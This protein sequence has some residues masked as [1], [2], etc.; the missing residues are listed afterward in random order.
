MGR[1]SRRAQTT[2]MW[3]SGARTFLNDAAALDEAVNVETENLAEPYHI[4]VKH[5]RL[6]PLDA[7][8][9]AGLT[10]D[11]GHFVA[12]RRITPIKLQMWANDCIGG[13]GTGFSVTLYAATTDLAVVSMDSALHNG[14]VRSIATFTRD[15]QPGELCFFRVLQTGAPFVALN[16]TASVWITLLAQELVKGGADG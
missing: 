5:H 13:A 7:L 16:G 1:V 14:L 6:T 11:I 10:V 2:S 4:L 9:G 8:P 15:I 12:E 3:A